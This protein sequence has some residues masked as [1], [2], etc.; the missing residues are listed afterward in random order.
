[1]PKDRPKRKTVTVDLP[2]DQIDWL[3]RQAESSDRSRSSFL[4]T[5]IAAQMQRLNA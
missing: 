5:L 4:R 1:M 2:Q 3:D